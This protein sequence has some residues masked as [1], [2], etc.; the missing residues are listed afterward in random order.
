MVSMILNPAILREMAK[1]I[2]GIKVETRN[3]S[4]T[5]YAIAFKKSKKTEKTEKIQEKKCYLINK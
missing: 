3:Y 1:N 4:D 5:T 2:F